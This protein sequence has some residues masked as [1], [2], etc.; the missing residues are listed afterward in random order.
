MIPDFFACSLLGIGMATC[1]EIVLKAVFITV[2]LLI[3]FISAYLILFSKDMTVLMFQLFIQ[4]IVFIALEIN[5]GCLLSKYELIGGDF[6]STFVGKQ[7]FFI[8]GDICDADFEK[9]FVGVPLGL[10]ILKILL[11][12]FP[13]IKD[14]NVDDLLKGLKITGFIKNTFKFSE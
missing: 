14:N 8:K 5:D 12:V 10:L 4:T 11:I 2:H 9:M 3:V 6:S 7:L 13:I 1:L